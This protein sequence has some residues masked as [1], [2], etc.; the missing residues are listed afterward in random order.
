MGTAMEGALS[1]RRQDF[2]HLSTDLGKGSPRICLKNGVCVQEVFEGRGPRE[3]GR[4]GGHE[5][6]QG[7]KPARGGAVDPRSVGYRL[8][9]GHLRNLEG[10]AEN[11]PPQGQKGT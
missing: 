10:R 7:E 5:A 2:P 11:R 8:H 1:P 9:Q 6:G 3:Q 4:G